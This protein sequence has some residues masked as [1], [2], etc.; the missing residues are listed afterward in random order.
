LANSDAWAY[1]LPMRLVSAR[2]ARVWLGAGLCWVGL[3]ACAGRDP[4]D[5]SVEQLK[6]DIAKLQADRDQLDQRVGVLETAEQ[7][8]DPGD[9]HKRGTSTSPDARAPDALVGGASGTAAAEPP[10]RLPVIRV[11]GGETS[12]EPP[13]DVDVDGGEPRPVV[14]ETGSPAA[15]KRLRAGSRPDGAGTFSPEAKRQYE[16]ALVLVR[17]KQYDKALD[18][19]AAFLVRYP[20][21]PFVENATYWR[22]ECFYAKGEYARAV[23]QFEGVMARFPYGNKAADALL[24]LGLCQQRLGSQEQ[25]LKT[26]S[27]L[28][29][30]YPKSEAVRQIP[31]P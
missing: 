14:Q 6:T 30:R 22:G 31:R 27:E 18:A 10:R 1:D 16:S 7:E 5:R 11:G 9:P 4:A 29:D 2:K 12:D 24:K 19:L 15:A 13:V 17:S 23:E 8:R 25:A 20:D 26:F 3:S 21:H 28:R